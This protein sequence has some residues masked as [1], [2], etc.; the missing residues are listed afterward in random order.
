MVGQASTFHLTGVVHNYVLLVNTR[1][2]SVLCFFIIPHHKVKKIRIIRNFVVSRQQIYEIQLACTLLMKLQTV[3]MPIILIST[4]V[5]LFAS[6]FENY[7]VYAQ[8]NISNGNMTS[9]MVMLAR[10]HLKA[11]DTALANGNS[12][13]ALNELT[14]AQLQVLALGMKPMGTVN[15]T[16]AMQLMKSTGHGAFS[17]SVPDN[18]IILKGGVLECRDSLTQAISLSNQTGG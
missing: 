2:F 8:T 3:I 6:E 12:T 13:A 7:Q 9:A 1:Y 5:V 14:M 18:C 11:A 15:M 17:N 10:F 4:L 16:Q